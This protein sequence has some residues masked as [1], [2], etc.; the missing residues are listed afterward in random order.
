MTKPS[1]VLFDLGNV[2]VHIN[3]GAFLRT[4][5]RDSAEE[6]SKYKQK[7]MDIVGRYERG[8]DSTDEYLV[9]LRDLINGGGEFAG[10]RDKDLDKDDIRRAMMNVIGEPIEGMEELVK[11]VSS[12][13][14]VALLSNTNPLHYEYCLKHLPALRRIPTHF[15]SYRLH[16]LKPAKQIFEKVLPELGVPADKIVF[17]DDT[18]ENVNGARG[19]GIQAVRFEGVSSLAQHLTDLGLL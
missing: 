10:G 16:A 14:R 15:L 7:I 2:L 11:R 8:E 12:M 17:I 13:A 1:V 3:A 5:G 19:V 6:R 18:Q 4:I 9:A